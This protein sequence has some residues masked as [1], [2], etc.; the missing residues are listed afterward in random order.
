MENENLYFESLKGLTANFIGDSLFGG[1]SVGKDGTWI[2]LL[3][4]KYGITHNNY[5]INGCTLSACEGGTNPIIHRYADMADNSPDLVVI[6]GGRN[7]FN[8]C[9]AIGTIDDG[10]ETSYCGA[11]AL[12]VKGLREKYPTAKIIAVS[13]WKSPTVNKS[14]IPS[15]EYVEAMIAACDALGVPCIRAYD[16]DASGIRMTDR[17][18]RATYCC[19]PGDVCHLNSDG[20]KLAM[21]FFER[22]LA[23]ILGEK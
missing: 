8:K 3:C 7:D 19:L 16:E 9:A 17:D 20:M 23:R 12:L 13:F 11:L 21:P 6:E 14:G 2:A 15:T 1:H 10:D 22:E 4:E 5:G 18:F